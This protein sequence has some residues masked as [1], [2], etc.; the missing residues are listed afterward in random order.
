MT[1]VLKNKRGRPR[2]YP[3]PAQLTCTVSG[4]VVKTNP[5]QMKA[6]LEK[7]G[8]D[9]DTFIAEYVCRSARKG[10]APT[11]P[12]DAPVAPVAPVA[13]APAVETPPAE[14]MSPDDSEPV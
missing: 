10:V 13:P 7:S 5:T 6:M 8:K 4:R 9:L 3:Y 12:V 2:K 11:P 1:E 14:A